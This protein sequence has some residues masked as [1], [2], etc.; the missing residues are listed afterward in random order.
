MEMVKNSCDRAVLIAEGRVAAD[1]HPEIVADRY[2]EIMA[3]RREECAPARPASPGAD[4]RRPGVS[5]AAAHTPP[6][7]L[8]DVPGPSAFM[9]DPKRFWSLLWLS[10][11]MEFK[12]RYS[13]QVLGYAWALLQP[14]A[15]FGV[16]YLVFTHV[17]GFRRH[18]PVLRGP[19]RFRHRPLHVLHRRRR[20]CRPVRRPLGEPW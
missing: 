19:P 13:D 1:G 12:V 6:Y 4:R 3:E 5:E 7:R 10:S 2:E 8:V 11:R 16:L 14:L 18:D 17:F 20:R 15:L 9:G